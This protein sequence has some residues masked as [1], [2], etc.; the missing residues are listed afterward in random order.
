MTA[1]A[2]I[3]WALSGHILWL[4]A[5]TN[6]KKDDTTLIEVLR[7]MIFAWLMGPILWAIVCHTIHQS[8]IK[9]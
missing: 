7:Y 1:T 9:R 3:L 5:V 6:P 2:I 8:G 4:V